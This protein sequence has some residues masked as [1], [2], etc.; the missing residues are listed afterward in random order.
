MTKYHTKNMKQRSELL[1]KD[2]FTYCRKVCNWMV[3]VLGYGDHPTVAQLVIQI[4]Y[5]KY[6]S[7]LKKS[8]CGVGWLVVGGGEG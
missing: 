7:F 6:I 5:L 8:L 4:T 2:K 3:T 1:F